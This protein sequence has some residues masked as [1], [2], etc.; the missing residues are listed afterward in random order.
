MTN[1]LE[2]EIEVLKI[3]IEEYI[4]HA[5]PVGSRTVSKQSALKLSAASMRNVMA[6][7]TDKGF[8]EQPHTS[9]GRVPTALAFRH[10][11]DTN[12]ETNPISDEERQRINTTLENAG[13]ELHDILNQASRLVSSYSQ[14]VG[15]VLAPN[16]EDVRWRE[17][18]FI[19]VKSGRPAMIMTV[20][21]LDGGIVQNRL[22]ELDDAITTDEL[23]KFSNYLNDNFQGMTLSEV[24][25]RILLDLEDEKDRLKQ[26]YRNALNLAKSTFEKSEERRLFVDGTLHILEAAGQNQFTK[27]RDILL[28]IEERS[29][30]LEL[31][32]QT[33]MEQGVRII[34]GDE[35]D[36]ESLDQ[37]GVISSSYGPNSPL[38]V[39]SVIG[40]IRM[41]YA[42]VIPVVDYISK[43]LTDLLKTR[44]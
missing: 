10:Y 41:N 19:L 21:I 40:P 27:M 33:I 29:R 43:K 42:K 39:V 14:Q 32:D 22:V 6:D 17:I 35:S 20:L 36:V 15:M 4:E 3:I 25:Y 5:Q 1:L 44:F 38:G 23:I 37:C 30:L 16:Q 12:L 11:L 9:A 26:L 2:R 24:R 8:L 28:L 18:G 34:L 7:L 13:L 31:L